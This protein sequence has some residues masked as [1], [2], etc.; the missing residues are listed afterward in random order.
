MA[1]DKVGSGILKFLDD[2]FLLSTCH[3]KANIGY[4]ESRDISLCEKSTLIH[5]SSEKVECGPS[6]EGVI[7]IE[8]GSFLGG[9]CHVTTLAKRVR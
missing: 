6:H 4:N 2:F 7:Y 3:A 1:A 5:T 8:K 9:G